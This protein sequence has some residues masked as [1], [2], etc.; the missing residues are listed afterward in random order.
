[1]LNELDRAAATPADTGAARPPISKTLQIADS[2]LSWSCGGARVPVHRSPV[3]V[4]SALCWCVSPGGGGD[5]A[6][7]L[8]AV[9]RCGGDAGGAAERRQAVGDALQAGAH[10]RGGRV[11]AG[12]IIG[13]GEHQVLAVLAER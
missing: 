3:L 6:G 11:E 2:V 12:S 9:A 8:G 7:D 5:A 10:L 13:D 4:L 1:M